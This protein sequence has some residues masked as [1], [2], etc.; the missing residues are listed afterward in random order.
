V[1]S[2]VRCRKL[3]LAPIEAGHERDRGDRILCTFRGGPLEVAY[4]LPDI[5]ATGDTCSPPGRA[6]PKDNPRKFLY[7]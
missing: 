2:I 3:N 1:G 5:R 4:D 7:P 6:R